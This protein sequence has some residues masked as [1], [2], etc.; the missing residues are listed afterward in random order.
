M[1]PGHGF[2]ALYSK[3]HNHNNQISP[4]SSPNRLQVAGIWA[5]RPQLSEYTLPTQTEQ[6]YCGRT[7]G[8]LSHDL[9]KIANSI[10][11]S[12]NDSGKVAQPL[13]ELGYHIIVIKSASK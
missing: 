9:L 11:V 12:S 4:S 5:P 13:S 2:I 1:Q 7:L 10:S 8:G 6:V 3:L